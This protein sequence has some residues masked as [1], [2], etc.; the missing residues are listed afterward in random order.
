M[1]RAVGFSHNEFNPAKPGRL[2]RGRERW[3]EPW[4][5]DDAPEAIHRL[6]VSGAALKT[7]PHA[8]RCVEWITRV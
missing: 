1:V 2:C 7:I 5:V 3:I 8:T 4:F 6:V